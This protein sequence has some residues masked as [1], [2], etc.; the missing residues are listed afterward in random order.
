MMRIDIVIFLV[1]LTVLTVLATVKCF[2]MEFST[3]QTE[4]GAIRGKLDHTLFNQKPFFAYKGIPY[5]KPPIDN[6]RFKVFLL[7]FRFFFEKKFDLNKLF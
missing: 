7:L 5:A 2:E 3:I 4:N 6:L 1:V